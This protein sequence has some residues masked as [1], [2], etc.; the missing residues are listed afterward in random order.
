MSHDP[1]SIYYRQLGIKP[2][3]SEKEIKLAY[4]KLAFEYHPDR[5]SDPDAEERFKDVTEAYEILAGIRKRPTARNGQNAAGAGAAKGATG[6]QGQANRAG[7]AGNAGTTNTAGSAGTNGSGSGAQANRQGFAGS[8]RKQRPQS[9]EERYAQASSAYQQHQE[10]TGHR[11][12]KVNP[13]A[14]RHH[15]SA[16]RNADTSGYARCAIT[17][18]ISA[19]PRHIEFT[20]VRGFLNSIRRDT[21]S[22][23][24]SPKGARRMALRASLRTWLSGFWGWRSFIPAWRAIISNMRGGVF[25]P[26]ANAQLL[27]N[28]A[29]AFERSGNKQLARAVLL[30][31]S[32]FIGNNR[33][34]LAEQIRA[35]MRRLDTGEPARRVRDE[36]KHVAMLDALMHLSP[37]FIVIFCLLLAFGP[38]HTYFTVDFPMQ[39]ANSVAKVRDKIEDMITPKGDPYYVDQQFLNLRTGAGISFPV[40]RQLSRFE[41]VFLRGENENF[42]IRI[43]TELGEDGYVNADALVPGDGST[44]RDEWCKQNKCD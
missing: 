18:V 36:W 29:N 40:M 3:A 6:T 27:F 23:V 37:V 11:D 26:E 32:D 9:R 15:R 31:A 39:V 2:G 12:P 21:V 35:N 14:R 25:P 30:Q 38:A 42:W 8:G 34:A 44:A 16:N 7:G 4:R 17:D 10:K 5:N 20:V 43:E 24:L 41:T 1:L 22:A 33:S 19:Q 13:G 28:Q